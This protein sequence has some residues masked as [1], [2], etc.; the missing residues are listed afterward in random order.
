[1]RRIEEAEGVEENFRSDAG[2]QE[3]DEMK[4]ILDEENRMEKGRQLDQQQGEETHNLILIK[5][6]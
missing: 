1:M 4:V 6:H 3:M 2:A 5:K